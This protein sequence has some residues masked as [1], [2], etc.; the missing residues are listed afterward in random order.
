MQ[1][2]RSFRESLVGLLVAGLAGCT[3]VV[4]GGTTTTGTGTGNTGTSGTTG[5]PGGAG[6][7]GTPGGT[8]TSGTTGTG[9]P[10]ASG[11]TGTTGISGSTGTGTPGTAGATGIAGTTGAGGTAPICTGTCTCIP[12]I[13][14]TS[15]VPRMTTLQYDTV[16]KDLLGVTT[17]TTA[18]NM[19]PSAMLA[20]DSAGSLTDIAWNGYLKVA[21]TIAAEV[22]AGSNKTKFITCDPAAAGTAGT[23]CLDT[24]IKAFGR[25]AFRRPL[26]AAE[27]TS[28]MRF[29]NLTPKGTGPEVAEAILFAF[30]ASPSFIALPELAQT[31]EGTA[32]KLNSHEVAARLSFLYWNSI[33]DDA[34]NTAADMGQLATKEQILA[35]AQRLLQSPKAA[36][37]ASSFHRYYADISSGSHWVNNTQHPASKYM[38]TPASYT[39]AM[40]EMDAFFQD[41]VLSGGKF[42]DLFTSSV[43][44][45]TKD[46]AQLYGV[47]STATTPTKVTLD[48]TKRPG[49]L[50]RV[51]FL[52]TFSH[53]D[54]SS[55]ILRGAFISGRVLGVPTGT[56]DP[57]FLGMK[58]P[59]ANYTTNREATEALT[60]PSPCNACHTTKV[61]PP[62]FVLE[63]YNAAGIWQDVD[64]LGGPIN[65]T[66]E[67]LLS[68]NPETKKT[69]STPAELMSEIAKAPNAQ[70][71]YA[72]QWLAFATGRG[73]NSNDACTV[74]KLATS[75][76]STS[77]TVASMMADYT[78]ADSFRLRTLGN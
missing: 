24:T 46:T 59:A 3:G 41:V 72:Q 21:E 38:F 61:N 34:L 33:P 37:V 32:V 57:S 62:G 15:Q 45:V 7:A 56:P 19:P 78:Q 40:A 76:A 48:A 49:F 25:K 10:G 60:T 1:M 30:L 42:Q 5:T 74:D 20:P 16:I 12:G 23:T 27:V 52:S 35:Q 73:A 29:N 2:K 69:V 67:V 4:G 28:F 18:G 14:A 22:M 63:R 70:K 17:L 26:T 43:G 64:P 44:F 51:G 31:A 75:L 9:T 54:S 39:A 47:T 50:T 55:P 66:A 58:P 68:L 11:T 71:V 36:A 8:G 13:P 65:S 53:D 6:T 77:Y